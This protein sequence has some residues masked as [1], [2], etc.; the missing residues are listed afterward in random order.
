MTC[1]QRLLLA[2]L[3]GVFVLVN[4]DDKT[5]ASSMNHV[6]KN[7]T[8]S[9]KKLQNE[10][11]RQGRN[12]RDRNSPKSQTAAPDAPSVKNGTTSIKLQRE[13]LN[14]LGLPRR[15]RISLNTRLHGRKM[16][17]P[18]YMM[19]LYNMLE[20][21]GTAA[22]G[23]GCCNNTATDS[24]AVGADTIMSYLN[25]IRGAQPKISKLHATFLFKIEMP[26]GE[27]ITATDF[28]IFKEQIFSG[29]GAISWQ[30]STYVIKLFQVLQPATNLKLLHERVLRSWDSGWQ[31]FDISPAGLAWAKEPKKNFGIE[32]SVHTLGGVE[33]D[34]YHAG[35]VGFHGPQE[36]R[37]FLVSFYRID[38]ETYKKI[39]PSAFQ[40][41]SRRS[42]RSL[43]AKLSSIGSSG[44]QRHSNTRSCSRRMLYVSFEKLGWR[45]WIIAPEGYSAFF[46]GGQCSFPLSAH[47]NATNHAIVQTLV[48][49][50]NPTVVPQPCCS[51]TK[52]TAISVLYF[53]DSNNVVLKKYT[54]M[55]V[56]ACGCH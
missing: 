36:K 42:P 26:R 31:A 51:P 24:R 3:I 1:L 40:P 19:D 47:V 41:R 37:P 48:H 15:P 20:M 17:A 9:S 21:N 12:S 28:R 33:L 16:S 44:Q 18:R 8:T 7:A 38:G 52:L 29:Q 5:V 10:T 53:D 49:L 50:M 32:L 45:D 2:S 30:N 6:V 46:C 13:I 25:H 27:Q 35:F 4:N 55:V 34:P 54:N 43:E 22:D 39:Y 23:G 11:G 56:K 14:L